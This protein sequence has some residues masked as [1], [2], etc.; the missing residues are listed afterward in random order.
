MNYL[1][2]AHFLWEILNAFTYFEIRTTKTF[3][4]AG[5]API[6]P[7]DAVCYEASNEMKLFRQIFFCVCMYVCMLVASL[8]V[9]FMVHDWNGFLSGHIFQLI[10]EPMGEDG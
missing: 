7:I 9:Y 2:C 1:H 6:K 8:I 10:E 3:A 4:Q 5:G